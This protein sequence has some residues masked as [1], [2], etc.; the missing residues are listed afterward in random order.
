MKNKI[1]TLIGFL[2]AWLLIYWIIKNGFGAIAF[3]LT[4]LAY[5]IFF[6]KTSI[7]GLN[8]LAKEFDRNHNNL[9]DQL[10][11]M[12]EQLAE[13][14]EDNQKLQSRIYDLEYPRNSTY[15]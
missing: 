13:I 11:E 5:C 10:S 4:Y 15:D 9:A 1:L 7:L 8:F 3:I 6:D 14:R 2:I 12:Q